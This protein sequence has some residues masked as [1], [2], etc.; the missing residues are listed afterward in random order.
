[1]FLCKYDCELIS[2]YVQMCTNQMAVKWCI[3][4]FILLIA[5]AGVQSQRFSPVVLIFVCL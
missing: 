3:F 1:M 5:A 2:D 4:A